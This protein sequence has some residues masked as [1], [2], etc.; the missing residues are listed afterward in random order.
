MLLENLQVCDLFILGSR[1]WG[2]E[3]LE[4]LCCPRDVVTIAKTPPSP[5]VG[6]DQLIWHFTKDGVYLVKSGYQIAI[7][8]T[9]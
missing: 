1:E 9:Q 5:H 2:I 3:L 7:N 4:E 8:P 6:R